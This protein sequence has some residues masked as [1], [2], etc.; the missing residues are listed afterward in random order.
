MIRAEAQLRAKAL[1]I[2]S[3]EN[4]ATETSRAA[5]QLEATIGGPV[6]AG[7]S[8]SAGELSR[9]HEL[10]LQRHREARRRLLEGEAASKGNRW[11]LGETLELVDAP[12]LPESP[13]A[14]NRLPIVAAS[15]IL[16]LLAGM[17]MGLAARIQ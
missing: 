10:A 3:F 12:A 16:G 11:N 5:A 15:A 9:E 6:A 7:V 17:T 8:S 4:E 2:A 14:P 13:I 1:E